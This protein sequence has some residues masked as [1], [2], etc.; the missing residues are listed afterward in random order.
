M[1]NNNEKNIKEEPT[2]KQDSDKAIPLKRENKNNKDIEPGIS[3]ELSLS[4]N[5]EKQEP[6]EETSTGIEEKEPAQDDI[7]TKENEEE[8]PGLIYWIPAVIVSFV[9]SLIPVW[10]IFGKMKTHYLGGGE[11]EGWLWR[12]WWFKQLMAS[13][14]AQ[15]P[16]NWGLII[17]TYLCAGNYPETGNVFDWQTFSI[18]LEP[19]F[20]D[21]VYYNVKII[22]ILFLN[23]VAGYAL[24]KY[25]TKKPVLSLV[26]SAVLIL[27]PYVIYEIVNGRPRQAMLFTLPLF[28]MYLIDNYRTLSLKSGLLAGFWL[29]ISTAVY[30]YYGMAC[31]FFGLI[32]ILIQLYI[33]HKKFTFTFVKY[34]GVILIIFV[35]ISGPFS[36]RYIE[37]VLKKERLP[38]VSYQKDFPPL[39]FLLQK[40]VEVDPRD[41]LGQSILRYRSDSTPVFYPFRIGY[42]INIPIVISLIAF[43]AI[44]FV[45]PVP[46]F[47]LISFLFFYVL[48]LGPYLR[49]GYGEDN[50][51][52]IASGRPIPLLYAVFFKYVPFFARLF[53][54]IRMMGMMYVAVAALAAINLKFLIEKLRE[55]FGRIGKI[56]FRIVGGT[57]ILLIVVAIVIQMIAIDQI[58]MSVTERVYPE[59]YDEIAKEKGQFGVIE[60]PFRLGDFG[61]YYQMYH[62][63]KVLWGWTYGS[64]PLGFPKSKAKYLATVDSIEANTFVKYL[65]ELNRQPTKSPLFR[66]ADLKKLGKIGYR[67]VI[68]HGRGCDELDPEHSE[69][70]YNYFV[71]QLTKSLGEPVKIGT[72]KWNWQL[73]GIYRP[74]QFYKLVVFKIPD[75][76]KK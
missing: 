46:W 19:I 64:I 30:L 61:N 42:L 32:F 50:Y 9:L 71:Q 69:S 21:P 56:D 29:G 65:E 55:K 60:L 41:S 38:E 26:G 62:G 5:D 74:K 35:I 7:T 47:W 23:G 22:L 66:E 58:P 28:A 18:V 44:I 31:L 15:T 53:A 11:L 8:K 68:L 72:E 63:K 24:A 59:I 43:I 51:V 17:Y 13:L 39:D 67:Y 48:T 70:A 10:N 75:S 2:G 16:K 40:G 45:R 1:Q 20:G 12:Y 34:V 57:A 76:D 33:D 54:P 14:L 4:E 36:F 25:L 27:N 52:R 3:G 49:F 73:Q 37:I 6:E